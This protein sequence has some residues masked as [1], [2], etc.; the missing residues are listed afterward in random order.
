MK[1]AGNTRRPLGAA[2]AAMVAALLAGVAS[3]ALAEDGVATAQAAAE[4][5]FER[6]R[7]VLAEK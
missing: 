2:G 7:A 4:E 1:T 3:P 6:R 5:L